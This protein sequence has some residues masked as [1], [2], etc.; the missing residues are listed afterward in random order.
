[1]FSVLKDFKYR[2]NGL[3]HGDEDGCATAAEGEN[4]SNFEGV[5]SVLKDLR[6]N[7]F[8]KGDENGCVRHK[9]HLTVTRQSYGLTRVRVK[10]AV[11]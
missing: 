4:T 3:E 5:S 2:K 1:L 10:R 8:E 11:A 6:K 7:G 9:T